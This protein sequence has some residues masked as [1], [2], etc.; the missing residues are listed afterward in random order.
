MCNVTD[1]SP[2][3][4]DCSFTSN[5][6]AVSGGGMYNFDQSSPTLSNCTFTGNMS[7]LGGGNENPA[8]EFITKIC[9]PRCAE[10]LH[11]HQQFQRRR[12]WR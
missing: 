2:T 10:Q 7:D 1:C 6:G 8:A 9:P 3:L 12:R 5:T 4:T 11:F